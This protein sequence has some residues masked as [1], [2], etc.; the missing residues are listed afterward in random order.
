MS[1]E[2]P[3]STKVCI[4]CPEDPEEHAYYSASFSPKSGYY[5]LNYLGPDVPYTVVRKVEDDTFNQVLQDNKELNELLKN[6]DLPKIHMRSV[7]SGG[8][9]KVMNFCS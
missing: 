9:G 7:S 1:S 3:A 8:V 6:Y 5:I 4:T 2:D